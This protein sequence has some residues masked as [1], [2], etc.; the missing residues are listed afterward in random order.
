[1]QELAKRFVPAA[2]EVAYLQSQKGPECE[3]FRVLAEQGHYAGRSQPTNTRQGTYA[4]AP[5]GVLLA[6]ANTNDPRAMAAMLRRALERWEG[7]GREERLLAD[8]P[9]PRPDGRR[10][11]EDFY[12]EGGLVLRVAT[13]DLPRDDAPEDWR[14]RAWNLDYAWFR[15]A[16]AR[17]LLPDALEAGARRDVPAPLLRRLVRLHLVDN[18]R[19]QTLPY[20]DTHVRE[21]TL[22]CEVV[23]VEGALV[24]VRFSG[25]SRTRAEG[26]WP[27]EGT[28][29]PVAAT[30]GFEASLA[31]TARYDAAAGRFVEF[32]LV[33]RGKRHGGTQ[34]NGRGDD[35]A[36][37]PMGV[38]FTLAGPDERV[39]PAFAWGYGWR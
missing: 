16:E 37:A 32:T 11:L 10:R 1:V 4:A 34:Y 38:V 23:A 26:A 13:R 30:R 22:A 27:V 9:A 7:L 6:S 29:E 33:A 2:D 25:R 15:A 28:G 21:A 17:A 31:G 24:D 18:V 19:G 39:A 8:A 35:L 5:S 3:L 12:P 36:P 14:A 20:E